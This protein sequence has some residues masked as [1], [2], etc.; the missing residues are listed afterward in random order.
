M[1]TAPT[2]SLCCWPDL[3]SVQADGTG[4][5]QLECGMLLHKEGV[6]SLRSRPVIYGLSRDEQPP[7]TLGHAVQGCAGTLG[8]YHFLSLPL[9]SVIFITAYIMVD[10]CPCFTMK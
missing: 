2:P 4:Y 5:G 9:F 10:D 6:V 7:H 3:L 1:L 8:I